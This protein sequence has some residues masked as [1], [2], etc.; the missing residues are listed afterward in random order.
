MPREADPELE[1]RVLA[2][3]LKL[4]NRGGEKAVTMRD[5]ARAA[6]T[7]TPTLY[8]R[9][10]NKQDILKALRMQAQQHLFDEKLANLGNPSGT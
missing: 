10:K 9:F 4:W 3:A 8:E 6:G 1:T 2:A 7:T 5:V